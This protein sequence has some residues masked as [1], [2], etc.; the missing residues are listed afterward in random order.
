M[1]AQ[2]ML[3]GIVSIVGPVGATLVFDKLGHGVPFLVA[4]VVV[5]FAGRLA[6]REEPDQPVAAT[7]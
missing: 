6:F 5:A 3:R 2:Q 4:A 1:G 7:A